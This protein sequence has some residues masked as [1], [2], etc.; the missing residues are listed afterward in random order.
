M[1]NTNQ[2]SDKKRNPRGLQPT[3]WPTL[4]VPLRGMKSNECLRD[5]TSLRV[6]E[7]TDL[8]LFDVLGK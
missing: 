8:S 4:R 7:L 5:I 6:T 3:N 1:G 2:T